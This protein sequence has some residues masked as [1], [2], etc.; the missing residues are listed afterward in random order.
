MTPQ[1]VES[2]GTPLEERLRSMI[3]D[4]TSTASPPSET[5]QNQR[6][7]SA[8]ARKTSG[9]KQYEKF[10]LTDTHESPSQPPRNPG[11]STHQATNNHFHVSQP[12]A[13]NY[14]LANQ[15]RNARS[16][17]QSQ[18]PPRPN[19]QGPMLS[20][21]GAG[22]ATAHSQP[23]APRAILH[24]GQQRGN[25]SQ[26]QQRGFDQA[27]S[28]RSAPSRYSQLSRPTQS[29]YDVINEQGRFLEQ[30]AS[31]IL[32]HIEISQEELAAK[33]VFRRKIERICQE[34]LSTHSPNPS[35]MALLCFGSLSSGFSMPGSD[36]DLALVTSN[37]TADMPRLF[38]K[39]LL[40]AG[41]GARLLTRTRVPIIKICEE[42]GSELY[43]A[44]IE[45]R[46]KWDVL[47]PEEQEE[48]DHPTR[49][50]EDSTQQ[51]KN[52]EGHSVDGKKD[53]E[54]QDDALDTKSTPLEDPSAASESKPVHKP[55]ESQSAD[56]Q[57]NQ[58]LPEDQPAADVT[59]SQKPAQKPQDRRQKHWY[60]EKAL[61]PLDF[62]KSGVGIQCDI[63][64][65]NPLGLHNTHLLRCYSHCDVRVRLMVLF[66]KN[67]ASRRKVNSSYNGTLSSYGYVLMVLHFLVN[68]VRPAVCPNLQ[69]A[70]H[71]RND[72]P[73]PADPNSCCAGYDVRFWRNEAE[74]RELAAKGMLTHNREPLGS[75]LRQFFHY[76]AQQ[77]AHVPQG[78]FV[79]THQVLSLRTP[80]GIMTK[81]AKGW[82][83][84]KT[85]LVDNVSRCVC[86]PS[87]T[88]A[89]P[90]RRRK[91]ASA[92]SS[93]SRIRLNSTTTSPAPSRTLASWPF[94]TSSAAP[95]ASSMLLDAASRQRVICSRPCLT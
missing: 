76:Y 45:A 17:Q 89:N 4:N 71:N 85:T 54:E 47:T 40:D 94:V 80:G 22:L 35:D 78:G 39:A 15:P 88:T 21:D 92:T 82:T 5:A 38:E 23:Y 51:R 3:L 63:N 34:A 2:N 79:W 37:P 64:F 12:S 68:V 14:P 9:R 29:G 25:F 13:R 26:G 62:P 27:T 77:G 59:K 57:P 91:S 52:E 42:P 69:L 44:L 41:I 11:W 36:M 61:G 74:I 24:R 73:A 10:S 31:Q 7:T 60:R 46:T 86:P 1:N 30:V 49:K 72:P 81:E 48:F 83:G 58:S 20:H 53:L 75:L 56:S 16:T 90:S 70:R 66:I 87:C 32:P 50:E 28:E 33:D 84:A 93:P 19:M 43:N 8:R 55:E 6:G 95:G 65:S 67:W 18:Y